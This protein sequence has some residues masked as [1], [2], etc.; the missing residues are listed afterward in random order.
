VADAGRR[1]RV[2]QIRDRAQLGQVADGADQRDVV[3][4]VDQR[5]AGGVVPA[6]LESFEAGEQEWLAGP[7]AD[8]ADDA[9]DR[10]AS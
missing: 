4:L 10:G 7:V 1:S 3:L 6:V 2:E 9:A 8:V 5:Q